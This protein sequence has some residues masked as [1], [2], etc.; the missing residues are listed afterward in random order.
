MFV[1]FIGRCVAFAGIDQSGG[2]S[3]G[4][5]ESGSVKG[6][7]DALAATGDMP[8]TT[9]LS[10]SRSK[11]DLPPCAG[12]TPPLR[13][14]D[15]QGQGGT[16]PDSR[17]TLD[18]I[19]PTG[20]IVHAG[21]ALPTRSTSAR[22][23]VRPHGRPSVAGAAYDRPRGASSCGQIGFE[24]LGQPQMLIASRLGGHPQCLVRRGAGSSSSRSPWL[25]QPCVS[26]E[27][28]DCDPAQTRCF[29]NRTI[30]PY[31]PSS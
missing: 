4:G 8:L 24:L 22:P 16:P 2:P 28:V 3:E 29:K 18:K 10:V 12:E 11:R 14:E 23:A 19:R 9:I 13:H 30:P 20:Q 31:P 15:Q 21:M 5:R 1:V 27:A 6:P 7:P 26:D 17:N 25:Q